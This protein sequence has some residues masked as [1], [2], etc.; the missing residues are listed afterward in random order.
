MKIRFK[1]IPSGFF[2]AKVYQ[3]KEES[4]PYGPFLRFTF[5]ITETG[6]FANYK[7]SGIVKPLSIKQSKF[8]RWVKNILG[9]EPD[10]IFCT[11]NII[12]KECKIFL[13]KKNNYYSVVDV[14]NLLN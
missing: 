6:E 4:G 2:K 9:E 14:C 13:S 1:D 5:T 7:F 11:E 12:G 3:I 10:D 8:Y